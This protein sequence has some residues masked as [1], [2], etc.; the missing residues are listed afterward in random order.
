MIETTREPAETAGTAM[1]TIIARFTEMKKAAS[2]VIS[3][4]GEEVNVNK[5]DAALASVG[6]SLKNAKGE[7]R[8]LDDVFIEL[9]S[10]WKSLDM[11]S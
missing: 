4:D 10:K 11:M 1:K 3:I 2:D 8:D 6:V 7:F 5:V 9:A